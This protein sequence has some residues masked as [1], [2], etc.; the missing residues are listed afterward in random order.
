M[1]TFDFKPALWPMELKA[2][3]GL[4]LCFVLCCFVFGTAVHPHAQNIMHLKWKMSGIHGGPDVGG[5]GVGWGV[6][7][8]KQRG[9]DLIYEG[10]KS[11]LIPQF[12]LVPWL[13]LHFQKSENKFGNRIIIATA[14][15][16]SDCV[17]T[18]SVTQSCP[19][20][21]DPMDC[22]PSGSYVHGIPQARIFE[23][24]TISFS[25]GSSRPEHGTWASHIT[26]RSFT[27]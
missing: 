8:E 9:A 22:S 23:W 18:V 24:A 16:C 6:E 13:C 12:S 14:V 10:E 11:T 1:L 2:V 5:G 15:H 4:W 21:C 26:G 3:M 20:L 27:V 7:W 19:T 25:W 17:V